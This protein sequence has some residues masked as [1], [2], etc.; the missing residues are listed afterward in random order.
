MKNQLK[1]EIPQ[2]QPQ[3]P[4]LEVIRD[5]EPKPK[6]V[7]KVG[8]TV[9]S[10]VSGRILATD[11]TLKHLPFLFFVAFLGLLYIA[12]GYFAQSKDRQLDTL[13]TQIK[14]LNTQYQIEQAKLMFLSKESEVARATAAMGIK[15]SV[16]PPNKIVVTNNKVK[17]P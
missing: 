12:N 2:E 3:E 13:T 6:K 8:K 10:V 16:I 14:D 9:S 4:V 15:E 5:D 7:N 1:I 11:K 17:R